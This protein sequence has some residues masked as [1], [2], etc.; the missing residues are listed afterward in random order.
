MAQ[1]PYEHT[2]VLA[3]E[4]LAYLSLKRG[5][6]YIDGTVGGAGHALL[7]LEKVSGEGAV[8]IGIDRDG[9]AAAVSAERLKT[10]NASLG[11][12]ARCEVIHSNFVNIDIICNGLGISEVDGVLLDL[13]VSSNQLDDAGRGFSYRHDSPLDMRM[14]RD[15]PRTA[16]DIVNDCTERELADIIRHY[17]EERWAS[18]IAQF[19]VDARA[20]K[21]IRTTFELADI[22]FAAVPKG[23]RR[24]GP[25]PARRTFMGIRI[26]LNDELA[27]I[28]EAIN[29]SAKLLKPGGRLCIISF[30]SLE[31]RIVKRT[32]GDLS[33]GCVCPKDLPMC[34][35]GRGGPGQ[36]PIL[37]KITR[38]PVLPGEDELR[39]NP[40]AR[41]AKLRV[42]EKQNRAMPLN[43]DRQQRD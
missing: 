12:H 42:A 25:H 36:G 31:D 8:L 5:G 10:R 9:G 11:G 38:K 4:C 34:V 40:R 32:I 39:R 35:C 14:D 33:A 29:K 24:D 26:Y 21:P 18:R 43:I 13:G 2:P 23:A 20:K 15:S 7:I 37:K 16:A 6:A 22:I 30:H 3:D 28:G 27:V 1:P 41:S 19:I 17:G